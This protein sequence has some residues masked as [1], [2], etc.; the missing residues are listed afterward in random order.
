MNCQTFSKHSGKVSSIKA[1]PLNFRT[2]P[3]ICRIFSFLPSKETSLE[4]MEENPL[5]KEISDLF[6]AQTYFLLS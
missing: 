2:F 1:F 5:S 4:K 6:F 3:K